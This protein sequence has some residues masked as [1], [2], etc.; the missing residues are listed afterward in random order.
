M[1]TIENLTKSFTGRGEP[2]LALDDVNLTVPGAT[3]CGVLG[4][5]G[6]GKTTLA[7]CAAIQER[8]DSGTVRVN[9]T[10]LLTLDRAGD[11][12]RL[13]GVTLPDSGLSRQRT[14]AGNVAIPLERTGSGG[15]QRRSKVAALLDLVGLAEYAGAGVDQLG[16]G[17]R[18]RVAL[19]RALALDPLVL[20]ADTPTGELDPMAAV[21]VLTVLDR[22]RAELGITVMVLTSD[23][24]VVRRICDEAAVL[25]AGRLVESGN[26]LEL[27]TR[28]GSR[29]AAA[30][31]PAVPKSRIDSCSDRF[32]EV[33][34]VGFATVGAL[35]PEASA[36]FGVETVVLGGGLTRFGDTP[37]ARFALGISGERAD[38]A[39]AWLTE[40]GACVYRAHSGPQ[41]VAA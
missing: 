4:D 19:A 6:A 41:G 33:V 1:I 8:P 39:L 26:L 5:R 14:V 38:S 28:Q 25:E 35:L 20:V 31:L 36:R 30:T 7:R 23:V 15:A 3:I 17:G 40:H 27:A 11:T 13:V 37:V 10:D 29:I 32:A 16:P 24:A 34:L 22:V 9:G 18:R 21:G 2:V 12:Q